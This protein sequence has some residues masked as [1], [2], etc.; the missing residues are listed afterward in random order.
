M[1][2]HSNVKLVLDYYYCIII[3]LLIHTHSYNATKEP[4]QCHQTQPSQAHVGILGWQQVY[5][6]MDSQLALSPAKCH[7]PPPRHPIFEKCYVMEE[8]KRN[9]TTASAGISTNNYDIYEERLILC[10]SNTQCNLKKLW[11]SK[12]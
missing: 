6:N 11:A 3:L 7:P 2:L 12:L 8:I 1:I 10:Q 9:E 4:F 5:I